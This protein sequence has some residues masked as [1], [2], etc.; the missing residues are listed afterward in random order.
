VVV[1]GG[2]AGCTA[3]ILFARNGLKVALLERNREIHDFKKACTHYIQASA[4]PV[5]QRLGLDTMIEQAGGLRNSIDTWTKWG[6]IKHATGESF[7]KYGYSIRRE[8]LD[9]LMRNL[10]EETEGL[11]LLLGYSVKSV[12]KDGK[13]TTGVIAQHNHEPI[14][15]NAQL[16]VGA[17]GS[18]SAVAK[19]AD[20]PTKECENKRFIYWTYY[21]DI[22]QQGARETAQ[23]WLCDPDAAY[24]FPSDNV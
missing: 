14:Q 22:P 12:V 23:M 5:M 19:L 10:V 24:Y 3:A 4:T 17:D 6:W 16:V 1:G 7:P 13:L 20:V 18:R 15:F 2:I 21:E 8:K 9:P 11:D